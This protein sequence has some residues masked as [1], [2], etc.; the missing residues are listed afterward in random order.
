MNIILKRFMKNMFIIEKN[1][2][3]VK[4]SLSKY[5]FPLSQQTVL[6]N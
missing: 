2:Y 1:A 6:A 3:K 4:V 5:V